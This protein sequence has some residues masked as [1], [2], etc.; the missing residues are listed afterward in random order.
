MKRKNSTISITS[1]V[2]EMRK[3]LVF[4][5]SVWKQY[6]QEAIITAGTEA[7]DGNDL[8]HSCGSLHPFG[9]ALDFRTRYFKKSDS[10]E[11]DMFIVNKIAIKLREQLGNDYDVIVHKSHIHIEYDPK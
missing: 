3:V 10:N 1:L 4:V 8:I 11:I 9:R 6:G 7:F 5:D 2:P